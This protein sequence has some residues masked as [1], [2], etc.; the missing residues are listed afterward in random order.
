[1]RPSPRRF[2]RATFPPLEG[3]SIRFST[4]SLLTLAEWDG[5]RLKVMWDVHQI[6]R[7]LLS[8]SG[9]AELERGFS[10]LHNAH[11]RL[12]GVILRGSYFQLDRLM[13]TETMNDAVLQHASR[14]WA[15]AGL[16]NADDDGAD[17]YGMLPTPGG[18]NSD[19]I[20]L[21]HRRLMD[22]VRILF[23][24]VLEPVGVEVDIQEVEKVHGGV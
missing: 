10:L 9:I 4:A 15:A 1:M 17:G 16:V 24:R 11:P 3:L 19:Q 23:A 6:A 12:R 20:H 14:L 18:Y 7:E 8:A 5:D 22:N 21:L 2:S 13:M